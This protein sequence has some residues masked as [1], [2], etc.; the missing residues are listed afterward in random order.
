M[1]KL[2][3]RFGLSRVCL[4]GDRGMLTA[5]RL[6]EDVAPAQLDWVTALRAPQI[7]ALIDDGTVQLGLFDQADLFEV[8]HPSY[9]GERLV[10]CKNPLL[11]EKRVR[12]ARSC[13]PRSSARQRGRVVGRRGRPDKLRQLHGDFP[14]AVALGERRRALRRL[15]RRPR[16]SIGGDHPRLQLRADG[17]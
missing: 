8:F 10:A 7:K 15:R 3:E 14:E 1:Q 11:A 12:T 13:P 2:K 17:I 4:V 9:P 16:G 6:R 5:A